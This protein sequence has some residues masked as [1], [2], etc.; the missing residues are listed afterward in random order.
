M[1]TAGTTSLLQ[2][3]RDGATQDDWRALVARYWRVIYAYGQR[4][5]LSA[6]DAEDFT[7]DV[8]IELTRVL[9]TFEYDKSRGAFRAYL[10]TVIQ[11]RLIDRIKHKMRA[12]S[13]PLI[14]DPPA[15][16]EE[17]WWEMEWRRSLLRASLTIAAA[18]VEP[19]TFQAFQLVVLDGW[20]V[21]ETATFL[22]LSTDSVYQAKA[23]VTRHIQV[24]FEKLQREEG[25]HD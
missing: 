7:Q 13:A 5:G 1:L 25:E 9:P 4:Q 15:Q 16:A 23:R 21:K 22:D 20:T 12:G 10:R 2:R 18:A 14:T 17:A 19:K 8:L 11:R 24:A 3:I 6:S